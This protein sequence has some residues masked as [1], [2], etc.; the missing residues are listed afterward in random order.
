MQVGKEEGKALGS[1]PAGERVGVEV[2]GICWHGLNVWI[3]RGLVH[4]AGGSQP[5]SNQEQKRAVG[6][7]AVPAGSCRE[8]LGRSRYVSQWSGRDWLRFKKKK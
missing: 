6:L 8:R 3:S 4:S 5:Y 7:P 2:T 1:H